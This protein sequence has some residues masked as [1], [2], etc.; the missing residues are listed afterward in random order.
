[1]EI[2]MKYEICV[3]NILGK[4]IYVSVLP[5]PKLDDGTPVKGYLDIENWEIIIDLKLMEDKKVFDQVLLHEIC[6]AVQARL[7]MDPFD[8][9]DH[10]F[11]D[12]VASVISE[13]FDIDFI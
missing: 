6:H 11:L 8:K 7:N 5:A 1:M 9:V 13:N 4:D 2:F 10:I 12:C 3:I